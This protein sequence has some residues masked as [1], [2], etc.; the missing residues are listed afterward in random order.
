[1]RGRSTLVPSVR[2]AADSL[3]SSHAGVA[4]DAERIQALRRGDEAAFADL[5]AELDPI[6]RRAVRAYVSSPAVA[7]EVVQETWLGVIR[8]IFAFE[9]RSSLKTWVFRILVNRARTR[10]LRES[11][12]VPFADLEERAGDDGEAPEALGSSHPGRSPEEALIADEAQREIAAAIDA[13]PPRLKTVLSLRDVEGWSSEDV[14]NAL[15][16]RETH[17]RVLLHRARLRV[18]EALRPYREG[19]RGK[20]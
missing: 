4:L 13:L 5:V 10:A 20:A 1:M 12:T 19:A 11:R 8:G 6:L 15:G 3:H 7:E 18:R 2:A 17:Q 9:G 14:C 16:I